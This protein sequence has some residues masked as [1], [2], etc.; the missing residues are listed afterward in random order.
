MWKNIICVDGARSIVERPMDTVLRS[1]YEDMDRLEA[2]MPPLPRPD[3]V[4]QSRRGSWA[5]ARLRALSRH[6]PGCSC[7][8]CGGP[9]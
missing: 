6:E 9:C 1:L 4:R 2:Q 7:D 3:V 5:R 8:S